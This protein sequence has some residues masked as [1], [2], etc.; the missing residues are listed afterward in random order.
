MKPA[1]W[2]AAMSTEKVGGSGFTGSTGAGPDA[3]RVVIDNSVGGGSA[4]RYASSGEC[5]NY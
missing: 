4:C 5:Q 1:A 3:F 2:N